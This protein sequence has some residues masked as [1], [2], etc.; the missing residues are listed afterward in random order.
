MLTLILF[1]DL[2]LQMLIQ[3]QPQHLT[4]FKLQ[5]D[6]RIIAALIKDSKSA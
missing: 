6:P 4:I 1:V 5:L 2:H 3:F